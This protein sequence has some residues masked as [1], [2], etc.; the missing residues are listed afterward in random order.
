MGTGVYLVSV[1][2]LQILLCRENAAWLGAGDQARDQFRGGRPETTGIA[3]GVLIG[4]LLIATATNISVM[5]VMCH[6]L[7]PS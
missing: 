7:S 6:L 2:Q 1:T 4:R 3:V 5:C